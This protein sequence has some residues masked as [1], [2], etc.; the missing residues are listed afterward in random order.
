MTSTRVLSLFLALSLVLLFIGVA[1][2][3]I[4]LYTVGSVAVVAFT[5][6]LMFWSNDA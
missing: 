1:N 5:M 3:I 2:N 4:V 6:C